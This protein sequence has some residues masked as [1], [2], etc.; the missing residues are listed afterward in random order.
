MKKLIVGLFAAILATAGL[1]AVTSGTPAS[2]ECTQYVCNATTT[3]A[4]GAK[5]IK[6]GNQAKVKVTVSSRGSVEPSGR[7]TVTVT[8]PGGYKKTMRSG[9]HGDTVS[10]NLGK[11]TDPGKYKVKV[12][13]DGDEGFRDS[14]SQTT[15][16]VK[17]KK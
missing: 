10:F 15:I 1:V 8:G 4:T 14:S 6:A 9:T 11:L 2:A 7:V 3:K 16:T 13:F 12:T 17:K 5:S